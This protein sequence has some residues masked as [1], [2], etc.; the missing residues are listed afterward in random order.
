MEFILAISLAFSY[1]FVSAALAWL[2]L[3]AFDRVSS[4]FRLWEEVQ[5]G[6]VAVA[7]AAGGQLIGIALV[8]NQAIRH[9][10]GALGLIKMAIWGLI[11]GFLLLMGY[12]SFEVMM[13]KIQVGKE[14]A[15]GNRAVGLIAFAAAVALGELVSACIS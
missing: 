12:L 7:L 10:E 1:F 13:P 4:A 6:N 11:G 8:L 15:G 2:L 14:L 5:K 3:T 9:H